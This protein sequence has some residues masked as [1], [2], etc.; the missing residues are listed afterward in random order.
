[1]TPAEVGAQS[2]TIETAENLG[3]RLSRILT[4]ADDATLGVAAETCLEQLGR[5]AQT[6]AAFVAVLDERERV[7][8]QWA[9]DSSGQRPG[10]SMVGAPIEEI[11][12]S[13]AGF[14]QIGKPFAIGDMTALELGPDEIAFLEGSGEMPAARML[15][16][17]MVGTDLLGI[18]GLRSTSETRE[19]SPELVAEMHGLAELLVRMV[20]RTRQRQALAM[21]NARARRIAAHLPD[22]LLMLTPDGLISW[23]SPSFVNMSGVGAAELEGRSFAELVSPSDRVSFL[24][25]LAA[26]VVAPDASTA[27][28]ITDPKGQ[29]RWVDLSLRLVCEPDS[30]VPDEVV[31]TVRDTHDRHL[32]EIQLVQASD[33]DPLTGLANRGAFDRFIS[34]L[35]SSE[36]AILVTFCDIDGFKTFNDQ[37]GHDTGDEIIQRVARAI[38]RSVRSRDMVARIGG[39]EFAIVVVDAAQDVGE[40]GDRLIR[41]VRSS[42]LETGP[43][44]SLSVGIC[45]PAPGSKAREMLKLADE[46]MYSAKR[47]GKD[48]WVHTSLGWG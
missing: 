27:V 46:A 25:Q 26:L 14:L 31:V 12:G 5:F 24:D 28:R 20:G 10:R 37:L 39:D 11:A 42:G 44:L 22:G 36:A 18:V 6:D 34:E 33:R 40:L 2:T 48:R 41:A 13:A 8:E 38:E 43:G 19:W 4:A 9:W 7:A 32:R 23:V 1:L 47:S 15:L 30:G 16:P 45:G 17:V 29:W 21:A 35:M 3:A